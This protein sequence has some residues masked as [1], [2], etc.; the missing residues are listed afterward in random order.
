MVGEK[1]TSG[2]RAERS[3]AYV[4][5][6]CPC[7]CQVLPRFITL[8]EAADYLLW[9][10]WGLYLKMRKMGLPYVRLPM[11]IAGGGRPRYRVAMGLE[12]YQKLYE[13]RRSGALP[14]AKITRQR[15]TGVSGG[16]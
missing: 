9:S 14:P 8:E 10:R 7:R 11:W 4:Q 6:A 1:E 16:A 12:T 15:R 5:A 2:F 13:L 3:S